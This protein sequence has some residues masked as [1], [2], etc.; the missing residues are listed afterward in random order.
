MK[1]GIKMRSEWLTYEDLAKELGYSKKT[2]QNKVSNH[3]FP[4]KRYYFPGVGPRF[5]R[6][7]YRK[8]CNKILVEDQ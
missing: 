4:L 7:E 5:S 3:T 2:I 6:R 1:G 8:L